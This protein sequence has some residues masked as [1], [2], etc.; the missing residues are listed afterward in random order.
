[1]TRIIA[2]LRTTDLEESIEF[3]TTKLGFDLDFRYQDFYAGI[4]YDDQIFHLK[5]A[6][7]AEPNIS[8]VE[9]NEHFHLYFD[10]DDI[11]AVADQFRNNGVFFV[12]DIRET[13]W[14]SKEFA[15]RDNQGHI[16]YFGQ[17]S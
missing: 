5:L 13:P 16:L 17:R 8:F 11:A 2:Q 14:G 10:I 15:V 9:Q 3:F 4:R 1:M 6:D 12:M 7:E